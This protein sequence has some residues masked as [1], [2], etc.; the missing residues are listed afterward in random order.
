MTLGQAHAALN[1]FILSSHAARRRMVLVITGKG[2]TEPDVH[3]WG[4]GRGALRRQVPV[5][6]STPPLAP[7]VLGATEAHRSHG[8]HGA[9]Y[10]VLR[11][12]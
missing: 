2:S 1:H 10:V 5:W 11:R 6:L 8:G 7:V 9:L 3:G 4:G 12:G